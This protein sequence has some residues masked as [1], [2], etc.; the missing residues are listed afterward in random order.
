M[1][2]TIDNAAR[3]DQLRAYLSVRVKILDYGRR[4]LEL[5]AGNR[6]LLEGV[7]AKVALA[8]GAVLPPYPL[9]KKEDAR[10]LETWLSKLLQLRVE[11]VDPLRGTLLVDGG[12]REPLDSLI[13]RLLAED[14]REKSFRGRDMGAER[15]L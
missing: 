14:L 4:L 2:T 8:F 11:I 15:G 3:E 6:E 5:R 10:A 9:N 1:P 7:A 12:S 13:D